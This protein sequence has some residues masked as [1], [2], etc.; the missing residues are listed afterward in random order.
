MV[1]INNELMA[2]LLFLLSRKIEIE[3]QQLATHN[4]HAMCEMLKFKNRIDSETANN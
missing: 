2:T 3:R 1:K 4:L